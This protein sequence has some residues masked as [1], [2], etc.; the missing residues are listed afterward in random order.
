MSDTV[1]DSK[2]TGLPA[3]AEMLITTMVRMTRAPTIRDRMGICRRRRLTASSRSKW[4]MGGSTATV[5]TSPS[6][7][8]PPN[9]ERRQPQRTGW[10]EG[11]RGAFPRSAISAP[12]GHLNGA[13]I[14]E[15]PTALQQPC[16]RHRKGGAR[17]GNRPPNLVLRG[18][19]LCPKARQLSG[20][21]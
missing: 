10:P 16:R 13:E 7:M 11:R 2:L 20:A 8:V 4:T 3:H 12:G 21:L 15:H 19:E 1:T 17:E 6:A 9:F 14:E 18:A 5:C